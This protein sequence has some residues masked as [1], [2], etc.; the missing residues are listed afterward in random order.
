VSQSRTMF[1]AEAVTNVVVGYGLA[2]GLQLALFPAFGLYP[3]VGQSLQIGGWFTLLSLL[4]SYA[5][6]RLFEG[7]RREASR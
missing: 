5:L 1:L 3:S 2:V 4:R 6:R 7:L